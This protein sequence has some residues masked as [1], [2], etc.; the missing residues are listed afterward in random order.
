MGTLLA[1]ASPQAPQPDPCLVSRVA[2]GPLS[3]K[4][5]RTD[6]PMETATLRIREARTTGDPGYYALAEL[7]VACARQTP[8]HD[9]LEADWLAVH[10]DLQQHRFS[11]AEARARPLVA[12]RGSWRDHMLLSDALMEQGQLDEAVSTLQVAMDLRP[13]MPL[14]D[15]ASWLAWLHGDHDH[16]IALQRRA[17]ASAAASDAEAVAWTLTRLGWLQAMRGGSPAPLDAALER[18]PDYRPAL[19]LRGKICLHEGD[20]ACAERMLRAAGHTVAARRALKELDPTVDME[21]V[22]QQ[23]PR[24][25]AIWLAPQDAARALHLLDGELSERQDAMTRIARAWALH[26][27]GRDGRELAREALATGIIEPEALAMAAIV[28]SDPSLLARA[29]RAGPGLLP[30]WHALQIP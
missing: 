7:A 28:L 11:R 2:P 24:G 9:P 30:S 1:C 10:L 29:R 22:R 16:A 14:Y 19:L 13:S 5:R 17:V 23:D 18:L 27:A 4:I 8:D 26:H 12:Q 21:A 25:F 6:D 15:R 20:D 3:A